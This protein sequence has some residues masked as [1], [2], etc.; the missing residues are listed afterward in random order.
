M[1]QASLQRSLAESFAALWRTPLADVDEITHGT[2]ERDEVLEG[3]GGA[4]DGDISD[5]DDDNDDNENAHENSGDGNGDH[6]L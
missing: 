6:R 5:D 3:D 2:D 4:E 1:D